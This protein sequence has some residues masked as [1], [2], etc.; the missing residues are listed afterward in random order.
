MRFKKR[1]KERIN[2]YF[3]TETYND[4]SFLEGLDLSKLS[5]EDKLPIVVPYL[6]GACTDEPNSFI[7][8]EGPDSTHKFLRWLFKKCE[9]CSATLWA[10]NVDYDFQAIKAYIRRVNPDCYVEYL[11]T[12][13]KKFICGSITD[14]SSRPY[15][16]ISIRDLYVWD[17]TKGGLQNNYANL[18]EIAKTEQHWADLIKLYGIEKLEKL[19][20]DDYF[21]KDLFRDTDTGKLFYYDKNDKLKEL[22]IEHELKYL[23][24]DVIG[25]PILRMYQ[26][27]FRQTCINELGLTKSVDY[28]R[29]SRSY[30]VPSFGKMLAECYLETEFSNLYRF[31]TTLEDYIHQDL[32]YIGGYTGTNK[33]IYELEDCR[34][35]DGKPKIECYDVNS[36]YPTIMADALPYGDILI[37]PPK[38]CPYVTWYT[39][40]FE[41]PLPNGDLYKFKPQYDQLNN[42]FFGDDFLLRRNTD[43]SAGGL[44]VKKYYVEKKLFEM[45]LKV[46]DSHVVIDYE[47][48]K[49]QRLTNKLTPFVDI[50]YQKKTYPRTQWEKAVFKLLLNSLY[51]KMGERW[52]D[53]YWS[54][55]SD[56]CIF[57]RK[58]N[59]E[60][61]R[62]TI[63]AGLFITSRSRLMLWEGIVKEMENG[64]IILSV[65]TDSMKLIANNPVKIEIDNKKLGAWKFEGY[66][67]HFYHNGKLKKYYFYNADDSKQKI[68]VS[69]FEKEVIEN[70]SK[71]DLKILY[72][73]KNNVLFRSMKNVSKR[74]RQQQIVIFETDI[75]FNP[76]IRNQITHIY[77]EGKIVPYE[78]GK[79]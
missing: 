10:F 73:P 45:F 67:T 11:M 75:Q 65:D 51:G 21:K 32:S 20:L 62:E 14:K 13:D 17:K 6:I 54:W 18:L 56:S 2:V 53:D 55:N 19:K 15:T 57:E 27:E 66:A 3:D 25:L 60:T 12:S 79:Y 71:E 50:I 34:H 22:D 31:P 76:N 35:S 42:S 9:G 30:S 29:V 49:Y 61:Y 5:T 46:C 44:N 43:R 47:D 59:E 37:E 70:L 4:Y 72:S 74:N 28:S 26:K 69:G 64:N 68:A 48:V 38:D 40:W 63:L 1:K 23:R 24:M 16:D 58:F 52:H 77:H 78:K 41:K 8:F 36:M 39:I 33:H 7:H